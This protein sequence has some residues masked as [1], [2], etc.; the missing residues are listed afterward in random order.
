MGGKKRKGEGAG[1]G[2]GEGCSKADIILLPPHRTH[3][4][5]SSFWNSMEIPPVLECWGKVSEKWRPWM[6]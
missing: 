1:K 3:T 2:G 6:G 5:S 4:K